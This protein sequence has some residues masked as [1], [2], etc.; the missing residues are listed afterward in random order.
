MWAEW[1][2][3][4]AKKQDV[5][6]IF[7]FIKTYWIRYFT[8]LHSAFCFHPSDSSHNTCGEELRQSQNRSGGT[9][10]SR[11]RSGPKR[12]SISPS[13]TETDGR[14]SLA[15]GGVKE[16]P[17]CTG[18]ERAAAQGPSKTMCKPVTHHVGIPVRCCSRTSRPLQRRR[19]E[20]APTNRVTSTAYL[21]NTPALC[22]DT[23]RQLRARTHPLSFLTHIQ[24]IPLETP[25]IRKTE[26][27]WIGG[28]C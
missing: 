19:E 8:D 20:T 27:W 24:G 9:P 18:E 4:M 17:N 26:A 13:A 11:D 6:F 1:L 7:I 28:K 12:G 3:S 5:D 23:S 2:Q 10:E 16:T 21:G 22:Q 25:E 15:G 14:W